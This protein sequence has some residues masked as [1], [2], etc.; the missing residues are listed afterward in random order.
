VADVD[1]GQPELL[2]WVTLLAKCFEGTAFS[3][4]LEAWGNI[5]FS[6][7]AVAVIALFAYMATRKKEIV[8]P[9]KLQ[10]FAEILVAG[11]DDFVC[12]ILG[13]KGRKY[14]P[15]IGTLFI[16]IL[17][18]NLIG[19]V[20]FMKSATASWSITLALAMIVFVYVQYTA[21]RELGFFG[22]VDHLMEKPR[23]AMA[24]SIV[25]PI[26]MLFIH[27]IGELVKPLTLSLRLRSNIWGDDLLLAIMT[28]FGLPALPLLFFNTLL[29]IL[30]C[31]VQAIVFS[32][33]T[34]IYFALVMPEE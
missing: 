18:M 33:L 5:I 1:Q 19:L 32:L 25:L 16:Y 11:I 13:H 27:V 28:G 20:P 21:V 6:L 4:F 15:F 34:T 29:T 31:V 17:F 8:R 22:Y 24:F 12:G 3:R 30:A 7:F 2:N 23:G 9:G 26:F 10:N 14:T